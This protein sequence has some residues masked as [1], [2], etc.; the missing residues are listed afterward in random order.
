MH[1][2]CK[3]LAATHIN[4]HEIVHPAKKGVTSRQATK[5]AKKNENIEISWRALRLGERRFLR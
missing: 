5:H 4:S 3:A 1:F 2:K